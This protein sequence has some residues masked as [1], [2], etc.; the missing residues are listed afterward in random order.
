MAELLFLAH[1]IPYPP[2]KG[3]KI[4]SWHVLRHLAANHRVHLGCF[5]DDPADWRHLPMLR[6]L[7]A[8]VHAEPLSA[9]ALTPHN[10]TAL[11]DGTPISV[12]H[13]RRA[14]MAAWVARVLEQN[15]LDG[16]YVFSGAMAQ[17]LEAARAMTGGPRLVIDFVDVDSDKWRQYAERAHP[18][19][20]W[21]YAR[22]H[23]TL[24][25]FERKVA[26]DA[27]AAVFVSANE[28]ALFRRVAPDSAANTVTVGNGVD[29][30]VFSPERSGERPAG[31]DAGSLVFTGAMDYRANVDGVAWFARA[32]LPLVRRHHPAAR[33]WIVGANPTPEVMALGRL[34]GVTVTGRVADVRPYLAHAAV[35]VAP[36]RMARGTQNKVLEAMAMARPVVASPEARQGVEA[37]PG[38]DLLVARDADGFADAVVHLLDNPEKAAELGRRARARV[39]AAYAWADKLAQL[40]ALLGAEPAVSRNIFTGE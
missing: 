33:F 30:D 8:E 1:R 35:V 24:L 34:E 14:G 31:M 25:A 21:I 18:P 19:L 3:D 15:R 4:R 16:A 28:A 29:L 32:I 23:R 39:A 40:E 17:Y 27:D 7:C 12:R 5:V 2:D 26:A 36:L 10:L 6:E 11:F 13:C 9:S 38:R 20:S 37:T 22:E